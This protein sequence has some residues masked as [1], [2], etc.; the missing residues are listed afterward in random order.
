MGIRK[1]LVW[2]AGTCVVLALLFGLYNVLVD[3]FGVFGDPVFNW[4]AYDMTQ[5]P[6][7]AK[8][9]YL[10]RHNGEY[11]SY[12]IGSSKVSSISCGELNGYLD[13]RFYNMTWYGGKLG[14]ELD[15]ANYLLD[16]YEVRNMVL[17]VEPQNT[18]DYRTN[19]KDLKERMHCKADGSPAISFYFDYLFCNPRYGLDKL[20]AWTRRGYLVNEDAVYTPET[21]S[22]N[23]QRRDIEPIGGLSAYLEKDGGNFP[24]QEPVQAM[25]F[26]DAC[27]DA[28]RAL[29][30][31]CEEKGVNLIVMTAPQYEDDF[32]S[33]D[34]EQLSRFWRGLAEITDFWDFSGRS[35]AG[36]DP[37]YFYDVKHFRNCMGTMAL[38]R[39]FGNDAVYVPED[40]GSMVTAGNIE[41]RLSV[42]W[43]EP[44]E[45]V[46]SVRV[47]I[48]MYHSV[49][50]DES[51]VNSVTITA[52]RFEEQIRAMREAGYQAVSYGDLTAYV[53][54]GEPLPEKPVLITFDDGYANNLTLAAPVLERYGFCGTV[55]VV[56]CSAGKDVYKDTGEPMTP[57]FSIEEAE[58][59]VRKGTIHLVSHSYD[60]HQVPE[61]DGTPC[62]DGARPLAGED[63][64]QFAA[65]LREDF[66]KLSAILPDEEGQPFV[67]T[68][69]YGVYSELAEA[70][71]RELGAE[72]SVTTEPRMAEVVRGLPQSLRLLPRFGV[73]QD[74]TAEQLLGLLELNGI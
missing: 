40:F 22:Y 60:L 59:W 16:H 25:P 34:R 35:G 55:A 74:T 73:G 18:L 31:R 50:E 28:V 37:R 14:D 71:L 69:P 46:N 30:G 42:M 58:P 21:G 49:T 53:E 64:W 17:M 65:V 63:D 41:T 6:R 10:E 72:V 33:F 11:D 1:W 23:K 24:E 52:E 3:P 51:Q 5:N 20:S 68:Y 39:I 70:A 29:K 13:A 9:A 32:L 56:G 2:F 15:A 48:L 67:F 62:R 36:A 43:E 47:P 57:H 4:Y 54:R 66:E 38:A 27:L 7:A 8:L 61:R 12:I 44:A 19:S 26:V 45:T